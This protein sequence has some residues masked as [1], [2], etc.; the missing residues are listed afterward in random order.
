MLLSFAILTI[1][2]GEAARVWRGG[3]NEQHE[4]PVRMEPSLRFERGLVWMYNIR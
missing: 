3:I 4:A 1:V 2:V